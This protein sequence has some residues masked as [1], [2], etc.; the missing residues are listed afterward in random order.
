MPLQVFFFFFWIHIQPALPGTGTLYFQ[1]MLL[2]R[3]LK[4]PLR[5]KTC[6]SGRYCICSQYFGLVGTAGVT[7]MCCLHVSLT[8]AAQYAMSS[9]MACYSHHLF[10]SIHVL[11]QCCFP[12]VVPVPF[13]VNRCGLFSVVTAQ[14]SRFLN[15]KDP[16]RL[17][18]CSL[19]AFVIL[20]KL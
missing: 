3:P 18:V 7:G 19:D 10:V 20:Q 6:W 14:P 15:T 12:F 13:A 9:W 17:M 16:F 2:F 4:K 1:W 11:Y 5:A 8:L